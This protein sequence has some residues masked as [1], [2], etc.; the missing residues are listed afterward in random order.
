MAEDDDAGL[1]NLGKDDVKTGVYEGGFKSWEC[2]V[3]LV[4]V[5]AGLRRGEKAEQ[6]ILEVCFEIY[7]GT[8]FPSRSARRSGGLYF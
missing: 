5:L 8:D 2:S 7:F 3:D 6:R 1:G 4:R